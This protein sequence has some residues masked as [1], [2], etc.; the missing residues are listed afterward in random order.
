MGVA[1]ALRPSGWT[2]R[3]ITGFAVLCF[4]L[5]EYVTGMVAIMVFSLWW[6]VLPGSSLIEPGANPLSQ[7]ET[8][9]LPVGVLVLG[10]L[11]H[12][13]Q[14]TRGGMIVALDS[15]YVRTARLKGMSATTVVLRHALPN[16]MLPTITEIGMQVGYL[17]G[18]IVVVETLF[19]YA[20]I[21]QML[22]A[23]VGQRDIPVVQVTVLVVALAYGIGNLLADVMCLV[24]DPRLRSEA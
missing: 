6:P 20:G 14:I 16:A 17:L 2:D 5:P 9:V 8:L 13:C 7:P 11:A 3:L 19:A 10:M 18:G 24:L 21:G 23:A 1:A 15:A 12:L 22:V 4:S